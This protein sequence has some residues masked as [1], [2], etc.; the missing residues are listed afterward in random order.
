MTFYN[1]NPN[2][3]KYGIIKKNKE[4]ANYQ[5]NKNKLKSTNINFKKVDG[6][7]ILKKLG[8]IF[9]PNNNE[10]RLIPIINPKNP[11][12]DFSIENLDKL[13]K[14]I[15]KIMKDKV[16]IQKSNIDTPKYHL[17]NKQI[18]RV[19][20][21]T[22]KDYDALYPYEKILYDKRGFF[23]LLWDFLITDH[24][25]FNL[26]FFRS[27]MDPLWV[28]FIVFLFE[29]K[30]SLTLSAF[31]FTDEYIDTRSEVPEEERVKKFIYIF[32]EFYVIYDFS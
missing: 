31:F 13:N 3:S 30:V 14:I 17:E 16:V 23:T 21:I 28:R 7:E 24:P 12:E 29:F 6:I 10:N 22:L 5:K 8:V 25:I 4:F 20:M 26:I 1:K 27:L 15:P 32:I 18:R 11:L 2:K 19:K 9:K